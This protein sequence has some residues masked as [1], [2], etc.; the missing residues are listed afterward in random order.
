MTTGPDPEASIAGRRYTTAELAEASG[1]ALEDVRS[2]WWVLG[3]PDAGDHPAWTEDDLEALRALSDTG[4]GREAVTRVVR[5]VGQSVARMAEWQVAAV[6]TT[7]TASGHG[8]GSAADALERA[9]PALERV[10][11][12]A[13]RRHLEVGIARLRTDAAVEAGHASPPDGVQG[14]AV[15]EQTHDLTVG[16]ADL[17][18]FS[19]L[20][21][22]LDVNRIGDL[23][24]VFEA[25]CADVVGTHGGR[26]IKTI[27]DAVLFVAEDAGAAARIAFALVEVIGGDARLPDVRLGLASGPV[28]S[29]LGDVFGSP[30]NLAARLT[31]LARRNR[32]LVDDATL[33]RLPSDAYSSQRLSARPVRGFGLV[34]PVALRSW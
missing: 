9:R 32:V 16:F 13:W 8:P 15:E 28:V 17:V 5:S 21:S 6:A 18:N 2:F 14:P 20:S 10:V 31:T 34:E 1:I 12:H 26:L 30:V 27:G 4:L 29:R 23:V 11:A 7:H 33:A 22:T 3:L 19:A 24:E 25:R